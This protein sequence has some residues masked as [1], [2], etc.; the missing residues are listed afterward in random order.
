MTSKT[1]RSILGLLVGLLVGLLM[2]LISATGAKAQSSRLPTLKDA[3]KGHF[4]VGVAI[5]RSIVTG[6]APGYGSRTVEQVNKDIALTK[7][8]FNQISPENDLKWESIHPREGTNGYNFGPADAY[9]DFGLKNHMFIVGHTLVWHGQTPN[10]V[11]SRTAL[12]PG[13]AANVPAPIPPAPVPLASGIGSNPGGPRRGFGRGF[14]RGLGSSGPRA[15]REEMLQRMREHIHTVVGRYK[16]RVKVWDVVNE[17]VAD[18]GPNSLRNSL[19]L[20]IIG[21]DFIAKA[22]EYAHEADPQAILRYNDYGL[23]NPAKRQRLITLI[24]ELLVQKVP[25]MAIGTQTHVSVSSPSFEEEDQTL[26]DLETLG[27]PI[28]ITELDVN[29]AE[30]GQRNTGADV[31]NNAATTQGGLVDDANQRLAKQYANL[32]KAFL[33]HKQV[34]VVTLWGV[35]DGISWRADGKPL[36][37]DGN[38]QP[39]PAFDA[40]IQ[41]AKGSAPNSK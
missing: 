21:P 38:D 37:F 34:K 35:N 23:E 6:E 36:L 22:F 25:V 13:A 9:V 10:W 7:Q 27:L 39:K 30:A 41:T 26:T 1:C 29:S 18:G 14:G 11:F 20:Q 40:V 19:W 3:Y 5:N 4:Y 15:T 32:F 8:Q 31:A 33:K 12:A 16:G 17:A 24:K 2:V 28:H